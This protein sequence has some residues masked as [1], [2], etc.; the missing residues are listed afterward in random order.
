[1]ERQVEFHV[2][3]VPSCQVEDNVVYDVWCGLVVVVHPST[4]QSSLLPLLQHRQDL[5]LSQ[6]ERIDCFGFV[7]VAAAGELT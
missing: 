1:M 5:A 7:V 6:L 3:M 4:S 2:V